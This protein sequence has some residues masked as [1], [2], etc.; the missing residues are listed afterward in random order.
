[1]LNFKPTFPLS[2]FTFNKRS[3]HFM[4]NRWEKSGS[5]DKFYFLYFL[6]KSLQTVTAA[7]ILTYAC[8]LDGKLRKNLESRDI[9]LPTKVH[10]V[11]A[12]IFAVVIY[13]CDSWTIKKVEQWRTDVFKLLEKTLESPLDYNEIKPVNLKGNKP[14][15]FI[16]RTVAEAAASVFWPAD[17]KNQLIVKTLLLGKI[18]GKRR[19]GQQRMWWLDRITISM[20]MNL[21]K[22]QMMVKDREA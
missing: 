4:A 14:W 22:I 12:M 13:R 9:T 18:E 2:S 3:Y 1:M 19:R 8:F 7:V 10:L 16:G 5:S 6:P 21:S 15:K 20:D 17:L 11:K